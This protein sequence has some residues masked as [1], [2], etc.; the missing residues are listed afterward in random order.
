MLLAPPP[1]H[2]A[3][4]L[5]LQA[6]KGG[7]HPASLMHCTQRPSVLHASMPGVLQ[8]ELMRH[9][10]Q[11]PDGAQKGPRP[12]QSLFA[13]HAPHRPVAMSHTGWSPPQSAFDL[14][15]VSQW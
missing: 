6:G 4:T 7:A 8:S 13:W 2:C 15:P 1:L 12:P 11:A 14:Q 10:T 5:L 9:S 3:H